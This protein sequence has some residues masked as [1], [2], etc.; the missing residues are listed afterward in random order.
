[1]V[2]GKDEAKG[3]QITYRIQSISYCLNLLLHGDQTVIGRVFENNGHE[4]GP[5]EVLLLE[6]SVPTDRLAVL[7]RNLEA[8]LADSGFATRCV[9]SRL[10]TRYRQI[11][12]LIEI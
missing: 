2:S 3:S 12:S 4:S 6:P 10:Q 7:K 8:R 11:V 1:M 5:S 9:T